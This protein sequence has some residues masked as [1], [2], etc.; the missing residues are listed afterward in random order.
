[1]KSNKAKLFS[2]ARDLIVFSLLFYAI[3]AYQSRNM[4][5]PSDN[6]VLQPIT[7]ATLA[8]GTFTMAPEK[9]K[10]TLVYFFAPWCSVCRASINNLQYVDSN[11]TNVVVIA[12]DYANSN[13]VQAFVDDV[14]LTLPVMLG[15]NDMKT[16]FSISAYP[17]YYLLD[18]NFTIVGKAMGYS[19]ALE[20][21]WKT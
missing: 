14:G 10:Q 4:L 3:L 18:E 12:L 9:G 5:D 17:S 20:F 7:M 15:F 1:M 2:W 13:E 16:H 6:I 8:G 19:T 21:L 11:T